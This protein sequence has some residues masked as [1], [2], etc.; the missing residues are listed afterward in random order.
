M[1]R[2]RII[3]SMIVM[4]AMMLSLTACGSQKSG[5]QARESSASQ[6]STPG[7]NSN[8]RGSASETGATTGATSGGEGGT[9]S[10]ESTSAGQSNTDMENSSA[11]M[12]NR[13]SDETEILPDAEEQDGDANSINID[14]RGNG[15]GSMDGSENLK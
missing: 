4:M 14:D 12:N 8:N 5:N 10:M 6:S 15:S 2:V 3:V 1:K 11:E 7:V 13:E 9:A